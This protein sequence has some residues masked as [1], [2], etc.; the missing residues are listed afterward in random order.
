MIELVRGSNQFLPENHFASAKNDSGISINTIVRSLS[1]ILNILACDKSLWQ[2]QCVRMWVC[3]KDRLRREPRDSNPSLS[4]AMVISD[5]E[6]SGRDYPSY[7][8]I[9]L[10]AWY[11]EKKI[12]CSIFVIILVLSLWDLSRTFK[13][14]VIQFLTRSPSLELAWRQYEWHSW[15]CSP[16]QL[17]S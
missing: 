4:Y 11:Q 14:H 8:W 6:L 2:W 7:A 15:N 16:I 3:D 13:F 1:G 5:D 17:C 9:F 10:D 12:S